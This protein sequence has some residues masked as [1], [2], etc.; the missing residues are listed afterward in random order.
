[1]EYHGIRFNNIV[2]CEGYMA[3]NNPFF[4]DDKIIPCKGDILT[5]TCDHL[6][7][8]HV[9]KKDGIYIIPATENIFRVGSTYRWN[10][11]T[12]QPD[13]QSRK[14]IEVKL[15]DILQDKYT[16]INHQSGIRPTT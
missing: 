1:M 3:N 2:F 16:V 9:I 14:Q 13:E 15:D 7:R 8:G 4:K 11:D 12:I 10:N 5:I 6:S